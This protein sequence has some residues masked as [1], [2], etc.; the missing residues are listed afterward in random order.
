MSHSWL[1]GQ[2]VELNEATLGSKMTEE[3]SMPHAQTHRT[4]LSSRAHPCHI[5]SITNC[6]MNNEPLQNSASDPSR[7]SC[8]Q[9]IKGL[10]Q[11]VKIICSLDPYVFKAYSAF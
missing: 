11:Y 10:S 4:S 6:S 2:R 9:W 7:Q 8:P 5:D 1:K 3:N